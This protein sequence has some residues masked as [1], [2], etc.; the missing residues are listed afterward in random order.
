MAGPALNSSARYAFD[1]YRK[2]HGFSDDQAAGIVGNLMAESSFNTSARNKGDGQDGSDSIGIGQWN[3][4]RAKGLHS[5][6][7]SRGTDVSDLD[8]QLDYYVH[9]LNG[10]EK[11][12]GDMIRSA[13]DVNAATTGAIA[14]ERPAGFSWDNPTNG[15]NYGLRLS[16]ANELLGNPDAAASATAPTQVAAANTDEVKYP[17]L[18]KTGEQI[19]EA[20]GGLGFSGTGKDGDPRKL[21]GMDLEGDDGLLADLGGFTKAFSAEDQSPQVVAAPRGNSNPIEVSFDIASNT[22]P[23]IVEEEEMKKRRGGL[24]GFGGFTRRA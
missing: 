13:T 17:G 1:Y 24:A 10:S 18:K 7:T 23:S 19:G 9:E 14:Y 16:Y 12:A 20:M 11:R 6:A 21:W 5:F 2:K 22:K 3:G 8:T 15:H 4:S